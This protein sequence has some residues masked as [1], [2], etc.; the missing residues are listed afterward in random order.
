MI[1]AN[2]L[3]IGNWINHTNRNGEF[4]LQV[5][6][7]LTNGIRCIYD[8]GGWF[9]PYEEGDGIALNEDILSKCCKSYEFFHD[10][11]IIYEFDV[12]NVYKQKS[13]WVADGLGGYARRYDHIKSLHQLQNL[14]LA[15]TGKEL[16]MKLLSENLH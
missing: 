13:I 10:G 1:Q 7:V 4:K 12:F 11:V 2:E 15:L 16:E 9:V 3:R 6:E 14:Y 8:G 5:E